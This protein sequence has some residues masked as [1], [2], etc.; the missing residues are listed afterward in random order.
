M[1]THAS[2]TFGRWRSVL[3]P[4]HRHELGKLFPMLAIFFFITLNYNILRCIKDS[5][6]ITAK[7]S[8]AEAIPFIKVW[9]MFPGSLLFTFLYLKLSKRFGRE[10]VF[11]ILFSIFLG[12]F[13]LFAF[14][15]Y[16]MREQF[17]LHSVADSLSDI[18]PIGCKGLIA[19]IRYWS[20]TLFYV[21][22]ELWG[23]IILFVL[24]WGF[25]N[26]VTKLEEAKRFYG[27]FGIGVNLSGVFS[28]ELSISLSNFASRHGASWD[29]SLTYLLGLVTI[30]GIITLLLFNYLNRYIRKN[31]HTVPSNEREVIKK[32][33]PK[34]SF[35]NSIAFVLSSKY[36]LCLVTIVL[37]YNVI[38]NFV[39]I[40]WKQEARELYTDPQPYN[41][42]MNEVTI[43]IGL[44][45]TVI[46]LFFSGPCL[47]YLG[48]TKTALI[49]PFI[50]LVTSIGFFTFFFLKDSS[51]MPALIG[52][53]APLSI[54]VFFGSMQNCLSRACKYTVFDATKEIA[55]IPLAHNDKI[56]AKAAIDGVFNRMGKSTGSFLYQGLL[57][58]CSTITACAPYIAVMLLFFLVFWMVAVNSLGKQISQLSEHRPTSPQPAVT[59]ASN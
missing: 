37:S 23:N 57:I 34:M 48:W 35:R 49:T 5:L 29:S 11:Y 33:K 17:H 26:Q 47:R 20:F 51:I 9:A 46:S 59:I 15:F 16:P 24:F 42:F 54:V 50:L 13:A 7:G 19:M 18:L 6:I 2:S 12:F 1:T 25:A 8:G 44:V 27:I 10:T 4:V 30:S 22:S 41:I 56:K 53:F 31:P 52:G 14:I 55:Y 39:E 58:M 21:M 36:T 32:E 43:A 45:A 28:G 3:W 38:I 40:L